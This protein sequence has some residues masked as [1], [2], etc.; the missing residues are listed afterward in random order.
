[1]PVPVQSPEIAYTANGVTTVFAYPFMIFAA[2]DLRVRIDGTLAVLNVDYTVTGVAVESGGTVVFGSPPDNGANV[3]IQR[4]IPL[5]RD[6]E[7]QYSGDFQS[8]TVNRDFDRLWMGQQDINADGL[9]SLRLP[10]GDTASTELPPI[11]DRALRG[12]AFD[13]EGNAVAA[14]STDASSLAVM[15]QD[16]LT[17]DNGAALVGFDQGNVYPLG[18]LGDRVRA[19]ADTADAT[20]G[21]AVL[22]YKTNWTGMVGRPIA[23]KLNEIVSAGDFGLAEGNTGP[24]NNTA[25]AAAIAYAISQGGATIRIPRGTFN[26]ATSINFAG[27]NG[28][29]ITGDGIDAT[30]LQI[31]HAT[32]D[33]I[34]CGSAIYQTIDNLTLTSTVTR[35]AGAMI[36]GGFWRRGLIERVKIS[37]HFN[38]VHLTSFEECYISR[39][40]I[41]DPSGA[42]SCIVAG[43]PAATNQGANLTLQSCFFRGND[44][45]IIGS[46]P[47]VG[48]Y[49]IY[50]YDIQA[51]YAI[52]CD[53]GAFTN[54]VVKIEPQTACENCFFLQCYFDTTTLG[55]NVIALG[56]GLKRAFQFTGCWFASAGRY[57]LPGTADV[58]ALRLAN[59]GSYSDWNIVGCRFNAIPGAGLR[60][61]TAAA[62]LTVTG[63]VFVNCGANSATYLTSIYLSPPSS[64]V[65]P[66]IISGCKFAGASGATSDLQFANSLCV[67]NV[68]SGCTTPKG[69]SVAGGA[70]FGAVAGVSD[71]ASDS[72]AS[73][74]TLKP[75]PTRSYYFVTGTTNVGGLFRTYTGHVVSF[76]SVSGFTWLNGGA[77][78]LKGST[79]F[80][81]SAGNVLTLV[82]RADG[83]WQEVS[84]SA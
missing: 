51:V 57:T 69:L 42:G 24:Q 64:Q 62:D 21:A 58:A 32:A 8:P 41:V 78:D 9:R 59:Q 25:I 55:E 49:G 13:A 14:A 40:S 1:M 61:D 3:S 22:G 77:L 34:V 68:I 2:G 7:Y 17:D 76:K 33:F 73:A 38:G 75:A 27:A 10:I 29:R 19:Y 83:T 82:C 31:T 84:R 16:N 67:G 71:G 11:A 72:M 12:M 79:N 70:S 66:M 30:I 74:A 60:V 28:T 39:T 65:N 47:V 53:M 36:T 80:V 37:R 6:I 81:A 43:T 18:T 45:N 26:F 23:D 15:L 56:T 54:N 63:C 35:T 20:R 5:A 4:R 48:A 52:S 44:D 46:P 50:M